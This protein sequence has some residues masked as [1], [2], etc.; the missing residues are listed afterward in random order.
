[1]RILT[2]QVT[3]GAGDAVSVRERAFEDGFLSI[4][5]ATD[6]SLQVNDTRMQLQHAQVRASGGGFTLTCLPPAQ[7]TVNDE[8]VRSARLVPGDIVLL[9]ALKIAVGEPAAPGELLLTVEQVAAEPPPEAEPAAPVLTLAAAG[10][11]KRPWAWALFLATLL[12]GLVSPWVAGWPSDG[13]WSSGPLHAAHA[14]LEQDCKAC[15]VKPFQRV[16]NESCLDCHAANLHRHLPADHPAAAT[17]RPRAARTAMSSMTS[18]RTW[19][20]AI[21]APAPIAMPIRCG[22]ARVRARSR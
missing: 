9:G 18:P 14:A 13:N 5:R 4:G 3:R 10:W 8:V 20:S 1:M 12:G 21:R 22:T 11:R 6:Q 15:H 16:R 7:A 17:S 2:R 19:C